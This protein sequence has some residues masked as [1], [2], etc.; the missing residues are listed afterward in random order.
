MTCND[1]YSAPRRP[2]NE[3]IR[4]RIYRNIFFKGNELIG[5]C[6]EDRG[7]CIIGRGLDRGYIYIDRGG[8][9]Y[10]GEGVYKGRGVRVGQGGLGSR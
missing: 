2:Y 6:S 7:V 4:G 9:A 1:S 8:G 3:F 5:A 10:I